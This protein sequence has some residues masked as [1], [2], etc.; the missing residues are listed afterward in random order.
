M[1]AALWSVFVDDDDENEHTTQSTAPLHPNQRFQQ[2]CTRLLANSD[3][4]SLRNLAFRDEHIDIP[5]LAKA[6]AHN[7]RLQELSICCLPPEQQHHVRTLSMEGIRHNQSLR[8]LTLSRT[9]LRDQAHWI[10][11]ALHEHPTLKRLCLSRCQLVDTDLQV[12]LSVGQ[13]PSNL[14]EIDL[15]YNHFANSGTLL[16]RILQ[17]NS[18]LKILNLSFVRL[19]GRA[20]SAML[21]GSNRNTNNIGFGSLTS[22]NLSYNCITGDNDDGSK[23]LGMALAMPS[24]CLKHL[25][26]DGNP[27]GCAG[28]ISLVA[29]AGLGSTN[30][31]LERLQ[32]RH[33]SIEDKGAVC[34][35]EALLQGNRF[36][37][38]KEMD[39]GANLVGNHGVLALLDCT[40]LLR[41]HLP[42]NDSIS[43]GDELAQAFATTNVTLGVLNLGRNHKI[44]VRHCRE[45]GLW[46]RLNA[47]GGRQ[48]LVCPPKDA[49]VALWT[50][51]LARASE[52]PDMLFYFL[53]HRPELRQSAVC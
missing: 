4:A 13:L 1:L 7:T 33:C 47:T 27:L 2:L 3:D 14:T 25:Q 30:T 49:P 6:L 43:C 40:T 9:C 34:L 26:L 18:K 45:I 51:V 12:L 20:C 44:G 41:L 32:L 52:Q 15:S 21:S 50:K 37:T 31:S 46:T 28:L 38:L 22:V 39:L 19:N 8:S 24:C 10:A 48:L 29:D 53:R 35:A 23:A 36:L 42:Q 16:G 11:Q 17:Q 5:S